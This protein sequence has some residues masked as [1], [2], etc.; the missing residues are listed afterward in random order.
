MREKDLRN[1]HWSATC[2]VRA[3]APARLGEAVGALARSLAKGEPGWSKRKLGVSHA[4]NP[5]FGPLVGRG[6]M[7]SSGTEGSC[8][9]MV[10]RNG[11]CDRGGNCCWQPREE[12]GCLEATLTGFPRGRG[13]RGGNCCWQ[14]R[15]EIGCLE[16]ALTGY[17]RGRGK[18]CWQ[19]REEV[20]CLDAALAGFSR[21]EATAM[22]VANRSRL[23]RGK[24][25][26][27]PQVRGPG[28]RIK[29]LC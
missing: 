11:G 18:C 28:Q 13:K 7:S 22:A 8:G 6:R 17:P 19:P 25:C 2:H 4:Y 10:P 15:E 12:V 5:Q 16:A 9:S 1:L 24:I 21:G 27:I 20:G 14:P 29:T 3:E 23:P 26:R